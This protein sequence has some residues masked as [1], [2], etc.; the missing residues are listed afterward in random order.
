MRKAL[1]ALCIV[2]AVSVSLT[3]AADKNSLSKAK[4]EDIQK[5]MDVTG[6]LKIGE[7]FG[8]MIAGQISDV[9][10]EAGGKASDS[11]M[12]VIN[13]EI[14]TLIDDAV[15]Q[16]GGLMDMLYGIYDKYFS[17]DDIKGLIKFYQTDLGQKTVKVMPSLTREAMTAGQQW[18]TSMGPVIVERLKKRLEE[19]GV[20]LQM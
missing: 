14:R 15:A 16:D 13:T 1:V 5:L 9:V 7:Q 10:Q 18:G 12:A 2:C 20:K 8:D 19:K 11:V 17:H 4:K 6:A 3:H